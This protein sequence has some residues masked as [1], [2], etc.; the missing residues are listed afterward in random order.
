MVRPAAVTLCFVAISCASTLSAA[1]LGI[2][3]DF[4]STV[5][6]LGGTPT[7]NTQPG[8]TSWD[9][10]AFG[11][12]QT[13]S[14]LTVDGV[15]FHLAAYWPSLTSPGVLIPPVLYGSR[16]RGTGGGGI[17][18]DVLQDFVFAEGSP[19]NFLYLTISNL[20]AGTYR[21][22]SWHQDSLLPLAGN[23]IDYMQIEVGDKQ[24]SQIA[25]ATSVV[26]DHFEFGVQPQSFKF[27]VTPAS[28]TKEIVFRSDDPPPFSFRD[29][30]TRLNGFTIIAVPEP[31]A[32]SGAVLLALTTLGQRRTR[33]MSL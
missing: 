18:D 24:G 8:F 28:A 12:P 4:D 2:N 15:D 7:I 29:F 32:I 23:A 21:M 26:V 16:N 1:P 33:R 19:G 13:S 9:A 14:Q 22:K 31:P 20:P 11:P 25:A 30:R 6:V 5:V 17:P 3:V 27:E 10:T